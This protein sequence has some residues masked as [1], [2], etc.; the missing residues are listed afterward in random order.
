MRRLQQPTTMLGKLGLLKSLFLISLVGVIGL[1]TTQALFV[2]REQSAQSS[3]VVG[4]LDMTV[5][6]INNQQAESL[7]VS[8]VGAQNVVS[9]GKSWVINN[10]GSLPGEF[11]FALSNVKNFENDCNEPEALEDTT[12]ANP[13]ENLGELGKNIQT[14]IKLKENNQERTIFTSD[15][16]AENGAQYEALWKANAGKVTIPPGQSV[17][18]SIDWTTEG[19]DFGNE[20]QSDSTSFDITFNLRQILPGR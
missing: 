14:V 3:F 11:S 19:K 10:V 1:M 16:S 15:L 4:T 6:G 12:C 8:G 7:Q 13:G 17:T 20:V 5:E 9:G 2:D 18:V